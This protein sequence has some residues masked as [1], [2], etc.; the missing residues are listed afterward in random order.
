MTNG[1]PTV[2]LVDDEADTLT[3]LSLQLRKDH[4]VLTADNGAGCTTT[5]RSSRSWSP[6]VLKPIETLLDL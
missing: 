2:L 5:P 1:R 6:G 3:S 4:K